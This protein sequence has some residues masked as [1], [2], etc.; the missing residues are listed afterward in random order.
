MIENLT[1]QD[2]SVV[3]ALISSV[4]AVVLKIVNEYFHRD[5][6]K[7]AGNGGE[8][9]YLRKDIE[10]LWAEHNKLKD[11]FDEFVQR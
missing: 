7:L 4:L 5:R 9:A 1:W 6:Q 11:R 3:I 10:R 8:V 2:V